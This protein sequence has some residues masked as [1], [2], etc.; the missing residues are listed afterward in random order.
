MSR[1]P[2]VVT[3]TAPK[4]TMVEGSMTT[5]LDGL[6]ALSDP[7]LLSEVEAA[8]HRERAHAARLI[9][10]LAEVDQRQLY[11]GQGCASLF[12]Y[13]TQVLRLSEHAAYGRIEAARAARRFPIILDW[14]AGGAITLTTVTLLAPHLTA[15][16]HETVL[17]ACRHKSKREVEQIV[18]GLRPLPDVKSSIRRV[19][20]A[21]RESEPIADTRGERAA[22]TM[23][24]QRALVVGDLVRGPETQYSTPPPPRPVVAP[25]SPEH[26][27]IQ[28]TIAGAT[29]EKLRRV[30]DLLRHVMP[31]GDLGAILD[32]ALT[33]LLADLEAAKC[34]KTDQPRKCMARATGRHIPAAVRRAV[35]QRDGGQCAFVGAAGRC[36]ERGFLE[37]HHIT[38]Y[39]VGGP[40]TVGNIALRCKAHNLHEAERYFGARLPLLAREVRPLYVPRGNAQLD[41]AEASRESWSGTAPATATHTARCSANS[42]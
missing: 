6:S 12:T 39:G 38:P 21:L 40:P 15:A 4:K 9:A 2:L 14:L 41:P 26:Y 13:C 25:L 33:L 5:L 35:W 7:A 19:A 11:L 24:T 18:A 27:K 32:R 30:Q 1:S 8:A 28:C 17:D 42:A 29:H 10:L 22:G 16:N 34:A 37:F 23:S 31:N 3:P 20:K 36:T